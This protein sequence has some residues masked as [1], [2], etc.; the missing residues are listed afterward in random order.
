MLAA[1]DVMQNWCGMHSM[2]FNGKGIGKEGSSQI[3][4]GLL[5]NPLRQHCFCRLA[6]LSLWLF[7]LVPHVVRLVGV[8]KQE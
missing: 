3:V 6:T 4:S 8:Q 7:F 5:H 1:H 2:F